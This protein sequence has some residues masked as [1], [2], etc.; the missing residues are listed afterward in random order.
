MEGDEMM[1][2]EVHSSAVTCL[3][4]QVDDVMRELGSLK[5]R[6]RVLEE[7]AYAPAPARA[8]EPITL[9]SSWAIIRDKEYGR[10]FCAVPGG[11]HPIGHVIKNR[12]IVTWFASER[13]AEMVVDLLGLRDVRVVRLYRD[14]LGEVK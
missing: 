10:I 7:M 11:F 13:D 1:K 8:P 14:T 12:N 4:G 6:L 3:Q 2:S 9:P 5:L